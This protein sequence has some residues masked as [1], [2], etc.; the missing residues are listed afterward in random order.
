[1]VR[2]ADGRP[3]SEMGS[4]RANENAAIAAARAAFNG[5]QA[6]A[7]LLRQKL[8]GIKDFGKKTA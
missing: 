1:M 8:I 3:L 4:R 5:G 7:V 6:V 2:A